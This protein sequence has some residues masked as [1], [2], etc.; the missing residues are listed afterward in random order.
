MSFVV[1]VQGLDKALSRLNDLPKRL[2]QEVQGEIDAS[3]ESI[4]SEAISAVPVDTGFLKGKITVVREGDLTR[5]V[6]AQSKYAAY[7]EF[8]TKTKVKVPAELASY[9]ASFKGGKS[10]IKAKDAI[11]AWCQRNGIQ[12]ELWYFIYRS[13]MKKGISPKPYL[14]PAFFREIPRLTKRLVDAL[15]NAYK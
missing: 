13:I 14:Y 12:K 10:T 8:G 6:V 4:R 2:Q 3:A 9:A 15:T 1:K 7:V 5:E 11:Y